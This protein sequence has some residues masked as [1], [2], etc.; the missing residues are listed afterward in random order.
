MFSGHQESIV[1][2]KTRSYVAR[3]CL[4]LFISCQLY[5][6]APS[7]INRWN[8]ALANYEFKRLDVCDS[9]GER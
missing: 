1:L 2:S 8:G 9:Y 7:S 6:A 4:P 5:V 3:L